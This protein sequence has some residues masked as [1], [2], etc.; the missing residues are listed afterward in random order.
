[1]KKIKWVGRNTARNIKWEAFGNSYREIWE[2][3]VNRNVM[4]YEDLEN[5]LYKLNGIDE[6][7]FEDEDGEW[8]IDK[9]TNWKPEEDM[10]EERYRDLIEKSDGN[11][12]YQEFYHWDDEEG[13]VEA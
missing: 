10:N 9:W 7:F 11:A 1:M 5:Y 8:N 3:L 6:T 2:D 12:Y 13:Y 4:H